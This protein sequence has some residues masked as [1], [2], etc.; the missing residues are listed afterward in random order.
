M[1]KICDSSN[2][3]ASV[4]VAF[5]S[6]RGPPRTASRRRFVPNPE[7]CSVRTRRA[8]SP[9]RRTPRAAGRDRRPGC[10]GATRPSRFA[11]SAR[12]E[13]RTPRRSAGN[14]APGRTIAWRP[15]LRTPAS[16]SALIDLARNSSSVNSDPATPKHDAFAEPVLHQTV[17]GGE[18]L[19]SGEIAGRPEDDEEMRLHLFH[20]ET[21]G[22][23]RAPPDPGSPLRRAAARVT[24][25][26]SH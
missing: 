26:G 1:R 6:M 21:S 7:L 22:H 11:R 17:E 9:S 25:T 8:V 4:P 2:H 14:A 23:R 13:R 10:R 16:T 3:R 24:R 5:D 20:F 15:R 19:A 12:P 18:Q